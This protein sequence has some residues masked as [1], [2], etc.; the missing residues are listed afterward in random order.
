M[1]LYFVLNKFFV[2]Q[3]VPRV[4]RK[5]ARRTGSEYGSVPVLKEAVF[6]GRWALE[7]E[8]LYLS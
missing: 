7:K 6:N 2:K 4:G 8:G 1:Y 5:M 3:Y